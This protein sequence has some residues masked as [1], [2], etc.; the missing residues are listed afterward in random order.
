[1][2]R[3]GGSSF[4]K[5]PHSDV[6]RCGLDWLRVLVAGLLVAFH[7]AIMFVSHVATLVASELLRRLTA[8]GRRAFFGPL[9]DKDLREHS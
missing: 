9:S 6:R 3:G 4:V 7:T 5:S 8:I 2:N 1:M